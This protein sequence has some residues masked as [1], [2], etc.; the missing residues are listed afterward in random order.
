MVVLPLNLVIT[1]SQLVAAV[2]V[3]DPSRSLRA[4]QMVSTSGDSVGLP[5]NMRL[6]L[7]PQ[8]IVRALMSL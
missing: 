1:I 5:S 8:L 6:M 3:N 7:P 2:E 4:C